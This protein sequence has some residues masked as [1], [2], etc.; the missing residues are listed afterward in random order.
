[1][2]ESLFSLANFP[3]ETDLTPMK[4]PMPSRARLKHSRPRRWRILF[5]PALLLLAALPAARAVTQSWQGLGADGNWD[6]VGN[7]SPGGVTSSDNLVFDGNNYLT[8]NN[9]NIGYGAVQSITF[10]SGAGILTLT[11]NN[12]YSGGTTV[13]QG[14]S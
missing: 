12:S 13:K 3:T 11:G 5:L 1:L 2:R 10:N 4:Q 14:A 8:T 7:F 6:T 9:N